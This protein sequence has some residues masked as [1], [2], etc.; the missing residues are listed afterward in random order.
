MFEKKL[1]QQL[2]NIFGFDKVTF[3]RPGESQEQEAVFIEV[4][5]ANCKIKDGKQIAK[6]T[7]KLHVFASLD[8]LP[9]GYFTKRIAE[10]KADDVKGLFFFNFEENRGTYRNITERSMSFLYLFDSQYDP[11]I[12]I[13]NQ[14]NLSLV[15]S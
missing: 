3:D 14:V 13:I 11:A 5:T 2:T 8:K 6:V 7:G 10:A 12:G 15:E 9:Y 1:T 4:E